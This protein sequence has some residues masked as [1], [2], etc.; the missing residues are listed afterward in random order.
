M[1]SQLDPAVRAKLADALGSSGLA[2]SNRKQLY[3]EARKIRDGC[4]KSKPRCGSWS[5]AAE[6]KQAVL[7]E[8]P[9][10]AAQPPTHLE[11][12]ALQSATAAGRMQPPR[13]NHQDPPGRRAAAMW[14][15]FA[16]PSRKMS[17]N[18]CSTRP[19]PSGPVASRKT[20]ADH[21][22]SGRPRHASL[23]DA[24]GAEIPRYRS[25]TLRSV[26][27]GKGETS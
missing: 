9:Q 22:P 19:A 17:A 18:T 24:N 2:T 27:N 20:A 3:F 16:G 7:T 1:P 8:A 15:G 25:P 4:R 12:A 26:L 10:T 5:A 6:H 11:A 13:A 23:M 14:T 21:R